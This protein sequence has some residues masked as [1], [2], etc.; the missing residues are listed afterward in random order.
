MFKCC[1][2]LLV[3]FWVCCVQGVKADF[4]QELQLNDVFSVTVTE[5][6]TSTGGL[7]YLFSVDYTGEGE[8]IKAFGFNIMTVEAIGGPHVDALKQI[9]FANAIPIVF[10]DFAVLLPEPN[11][12]THALVTSSEILDAGS[13]ESTSEFFF[14]VA[15]REGTQRSFD[16]ATVAIDP[17]PDGATN[18]DGSRTSV[19]FE[20][21]VGLVSDIGESYG[22]TPETRPIL[23][24]F[25]IPEPGAMAGFVLVGVAAL[26]RRKKV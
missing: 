10:N 15:F 22:A 4:Q 24:F 8:G 17:L 7:S 9:S 5:R 2:L 1:F 21:G 13:G 12:D 3:V 11:D 6:E 25:L 19:I 23:T 26:G 20:Y 14:D 16:L 18:G